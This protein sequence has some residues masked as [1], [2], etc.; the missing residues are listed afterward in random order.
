MPENG[1]ARRKSSP[2]YST[3]LAL[4]VGLVLSRTSNIEGEQPEL[5]DN[6]C[7]CVIMP[8]PNDP[9]DVTDNKA[10]K[11]PTAFSLGLRPHEPRGHQCNNHGG[12]LHRSKESVRRQCARLLPL[13]SSCG[14]S[15][16][17]MP[18]SLLRTLVP[19]LARPEH[20]LIEKSPY[21]LPSLLVGEVSFRVKE[22]TGVTNHRLRLG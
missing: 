22:I 7:V 15:P 4:T 17:V 8:A 2:L 19:E 20:E 1:L 21:V 3:R 18:G 6:K 16:H 12:P 5:Q 9:K 10:P 13:S 14:S 11:T